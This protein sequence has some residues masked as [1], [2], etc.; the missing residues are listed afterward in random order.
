MSQPWSSLPQVLAAD[1]AE[2]W[3]S[4]FAD[5]VPSW[6]TESGAITTELLAAAIASSPFLGQTLQRQPDAV[7]Q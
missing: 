3:P 6:L 4:I 2:R 7:R 1:V 5:G